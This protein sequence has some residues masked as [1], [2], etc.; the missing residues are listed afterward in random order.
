[1]NRVLV[2][3]CVLAVL[4]FS[5]ILGRDLIDYRIS[6]LDFL[7]EQAAEIKESSDTLSIV[8]KYELIRRRIERGENALST[9]QSPDSAQIL[10]ET[11]PF[12]HGKVHL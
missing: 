9:N 6:E 7:L 8:G 12:R 2:L 3:V 4:V 10:F 11:T 5:S 1:M